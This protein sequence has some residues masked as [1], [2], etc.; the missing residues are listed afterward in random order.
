MDNIISLMHST[1]N[2]YDFSMKIEGMNF[3][4]EELDVRFV[5]DCVSVLH[6]FRCKQDLD[7]FTVEIPRLNF[8]EKTMYQFRIEVST[9]NGYF[10]VPF[11]GSVNVVDP[12]SLNIPNIN[13]TTIVKPR[14]PAVYVP[15]VKAHV[16][17]KTLAQTTESILAMAGMKPNKAKVSKPVE[18]TEIKTPDLVIN[19]T[20]KP[21]AKFE[22]PEDVNKKIKSFLKDI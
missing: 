11:K 19:E 2:S 16:S 13:N 1:P 14:E 3:K 7:R 18:T 8:L 20:T 17:E 22:I 10:F 12:P 5:I 6:S 9:A 4:P 21:G 15:P